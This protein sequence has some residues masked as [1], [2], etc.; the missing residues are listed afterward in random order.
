M[1]QCFAIIA[2]TLGLCARGNEA[3]ETDDPYADI[4]EGA[5]LVRFE[6]NP[7]IPAEQCDPN[8]HCAMRTQEGAILVNANYEV[9]DQSL[10]GAGFGI[11]DR[12]KVGV[13]T[14]TSEF[15]MF[16]A[17]P[18]PCSELDVRVQELTC[19]TE[20]DDETNVC[21]TLKFEGT[22]IFGNFRD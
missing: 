4:T 18:V 17:Y 19:R 8:P 5:L 9:V 13:A 12:E 11:I 14:A 10:N 21:P 6:A 1:Y 3:A 20:D 15:N 2:A 22:E 7:D 16:D